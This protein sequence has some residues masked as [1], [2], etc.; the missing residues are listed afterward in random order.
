MLEW[1]FQFYSGTHYDS[2]MNE[3][4][5]TNT[6]S[7]NEKRSPEAVECSMVMLHSVHYIFSSSG[8]SVFDKP[9]PSIHALIIF[10]FSGLNN[11][12]VLLARGHCQRFSG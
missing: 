2:D 6:D 10:I 9:N 12:D 11:K 4:R 5:P 7:V 8:M 1:R 3:M